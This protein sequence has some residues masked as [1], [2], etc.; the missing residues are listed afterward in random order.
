[1]AR[2]YLSFATKIAGVVTLVAATGVLVCTLAVACVVYLDGQADAVLH[3][4]ADTSRISNELTDHLND[5]S[6]VSRE[7]RQLIEA[8]L[9]TDGMPRSVVIR[10]LRDILAREPDLQG[11]WLIAEPNGFDQRDYAFRGAFGSSAS[12]EFFPYW[13]R[14]SGGRIVQDTTGKRDDVAADRASPFYRDPALRNDTVLTQPYR[15]VLGEGDGVV[16]IMSSLATPVRTGSRLVGVVGVDLYL[17]DLSRIIAREAGASLGQYALVS[18]T[19]RIVLASDTNLLNQPV[20]K[21]PLAGAGLTSNSAKGWSLQRWNGEPSIIVTQAVRFT[22]ATGAW[23]LV[24]AEPTSAALAR[25]WKMVGLTLLVGGL[26]VLLAAWLGARFGRALAIPISSM[27]SA[28]RQ[29]AE[30]DLN[31]RLE[32]GADGPEFDHL[33]QALG[34]FRDFAHRA[35]QAEEAHQAAEKEVRDRSAQLRITSANLPLEDFLVLATQEALIATEADGAIIEMLEGDLLVARA[36]S[37]LLESFVGMTIPV[38]GS[39]SGEGM[40]QQRAQ[41][42][43]DSET[44]P[45]VNVAIARQSGMR[46]IALTPLIAGERAI[47][48]LKV[49]SVGANAFSQRDTA[50]LQIL[51]DVLGTA[52]SREVAREALE[53]ANRAK[54]EFLA[55]M[56]HEIRTP[57]NGVIGMADILARSPLGPEDLQKV[58]VIRASSETLN[59]LLTDILDSARMEAGQLSI[60]PKAFQLGAA[61]REVAALHRPQAEAKGLTI[62]LTIGP[63]VDGAFVG[64]A[65]RIKQVLTNLVSNAI[66]FTDTGGVTILA[67]YGDE[68][69]L[70]LRVADTG[71]GFDPAVQARLFE[72]FRQADGSITRRFGGSGLGLAISQQL[73]ELMN[74]QITCKSTPGCGSAFTFALPLQAAPNAEL[75]PVL[76]AEED[77]GMDKAS[78]DNLRV[79]VA[80]DHPTNRQV[81]EL[82]LSQIGARVLTVEDGEQAVRAFE[83]GAFDLILMDM[84]MPVMDGLQATREIRRIETILGRSPTP[85]LMLTANALP[86]HVTASTAAGADGHL[87][88]PITAATLFA[89]IGECCARSEDLVA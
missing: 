52:L 33:A 21:L 15:W 51:A 86:D 28:L 46:S 17:D 83:T 11:V 76:G 36:A 56:S 22:G 25:T 44:D 66:K 26:L 12:G 69:H 57:L 75:A 63:A 4:R 79:L 37:G 39:L 13:Y 85:I 35:I 32:H 19:G 74:G 30:G 84:Q 18:N 43:Q 70:T 42:S 58:E 88:K 50:A 71:V 61:I 23:T 60:E 77:V 38:D 41:L 24:V 68:H 49:A 45:R 14:N 48:V 29:M 3:A 10:R 6:Q 34:A 81:V 31:A 62:S 55:N 72:R 59:R 78:S 89:A 73:A 16:R 7:V 40:R 9:V 20:S 64:D 67:D 53:N 80:D 47:G 1:M 5:A 82:M 87:S 65:V 2:K 54:S 27:S 8:A